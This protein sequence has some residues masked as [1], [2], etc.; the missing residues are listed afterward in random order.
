MSAIT[1]EGGWVPGG[2]VYHGPCP[3]CGK[4]TVIAGP[5]DVP[6]TCTVCRASL[7]AAM[8]PEIAE[9]NAAVYGRSQERA[10]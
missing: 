4:P 6:T 3:Q 5:G 1:P 9:W 7:L 2:R 8:A 10:L